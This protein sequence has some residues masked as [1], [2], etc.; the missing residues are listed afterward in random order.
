MAAYLLGLDIGTSAC[1]AALFS[2][3]GQL[4]GKAER[5]YQ[6]YCPY[7]GW[8]EQNPEDWWKATYESIR[9][10]L[11]ST[12]VSSAD[13]AGIGVDG[14]SWSMVLLDAKGRV[15]MPSPIWTDTRAMSVCSDMLSVVPDIVE[16]SGN[17][18]VPG[19]TTPKLLWLKKAY[20][21]VYQRVAKVLQSNGFIVQRLTGKCSL[22]VSQ[23]YGWHCFSNKNM[24]WDDEVIH[25]LQID[26]R[27]LPP[28]HACHQIVGGV[29]E[30]AA[31]LTGLVV[32]TPVMAGGLDAAAGTL[33][34]GVT[35]N[36]ETQEQAGQAG[37]MSICLDRYVS[38]PQLILSAHVVPGR[39]LLQGGTTGGGGAFKWLNEQCCP[40][41][42]FEQMT[43]LAENVPPLSKGMIFLPYMSGERTPLWLPEAQGVFYGLSLHVG[44]VEMIRAVMEGVAYALKHNLDTA[45]QAGCRVKR[46]RSSG[47]CA[48]SELWM[49]I[50]AD[51]TG[52][53]MQTANS[54]NATVRGAA[55]IAGVGVGAL[56]GWNVWKPD[57]ASLIC[58]DP[59]EAM[60]VVYRKGYE[61]YLQ[62]LGTMLPFYQKGINNL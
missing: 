42:T 34:V 17:P 30:D 3:D 8:V 20:P 14:Q 2:V 53:I 61:Q 47:G 13:I 9:E 39:W 12:N 56:S 28:L 35:D 31:R 11:Q 45:L 10:L 7:S 23:A 36:G 18:A 25:E 41:L 24:T 6:T 46:M 4:I 57:D 15:L 58:Y 44:R 33:G 43:S 5:S 16:R 38:H 21:S 37:G 27:L 49:R 1:K 60:Q 32:G 48:R 59:N 52:C 22:D 26:R 40:D 51:A 62:L 54:E 29:S 55:I 19:Y 50:K